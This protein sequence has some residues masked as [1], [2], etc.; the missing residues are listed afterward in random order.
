MPYTW[1]ESIRTPNILRQLYLGEYEGLQS[2][3]RAFLC[4]VITQFCV[5]LSLPVL[6]QR[7]SRAGVFLQPPGA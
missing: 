7:S 3:L 2:M 5:L 4:K 1:K 6:C